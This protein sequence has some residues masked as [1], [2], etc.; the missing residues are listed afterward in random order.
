MLAAEAIPALVKLLMAESE[1]EF[2]QHIGNVIQS[3]GPANL[4]G[5]EEFRQHV[6][7]ELIDWA[8]QSDRIDL[9]RV[10]ISVIASFG[11]SA[12]PPLINLALRTDIHVGI[13]M[14]GSASRSWHFKTCSSFPT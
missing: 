6:V 9:L 2:C 1:Y 8:T 4:Q 11:K 3:I 12:I 10:Y 14:A 7:N 13:A 5:S